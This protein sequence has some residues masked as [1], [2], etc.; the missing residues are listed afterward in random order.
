MQGSKPAQDKPALLAAIR[1]AF[2]IYEAEATLGALE[3]CIDAC[4]R[5][6]PALDETKVEHGNAVLQLAELLGDR[7]TK[8]RS[9]AHWAQANGLIDKFR[10]HIPDGDWR[11][12]LYA[13]A[14]G[15]LL[16]RRA[17]ATQAADDIANA[18]S[19]LQ[20]ARAMVRFGSFVNRISSL[21]QG[22]LRLRRFEAERDPGDLEAALADSGAVLAS[23]HTLPPHV[24]ATAK[25]FARAAYL[26]AD[27]V[28]ADGHLDLA[29]DA[30][31][32][33]LALTNDPIDISDLQGALGSLLRERFNR[34]GAAA[35]ID[36]A[37]EAYRTC[38]RLPGLSDAQ[39]AARIDNLGNGL[40]A[41]YAS[42]KD[43]VDLDAMV[44]CHKEA[45][46][47]SMTDSPDRARFHANLASS[48]LTRWRSCR[49]RAALNEAHATLMAGLRCEVVPISV[50]ALLNALMLEALLESDAGTGTDAHLNEAVAA[51]EA[52]LRAF[53]SSEGDNPVPYR[54]AARARSSPVTRRLLGALL[55]RAGRRSETK[56]ADLRRAVAIGEAA[57]V[58]LL[59]REL[60]RRSLAA[61]ADIREGDLFSEKQ[62]LAE[63]AAY[64]VHDMAPADNLSEARRLRRIA[65]RRSAWGA[66][67]QVWDEISA[68]CPAG[69]EYVRIRR[70]VSAALDTALQNRPPDWLLLSML[71]IEELSP[72]GRWQQGFCVIALPPAPAALQL[73]CSGPHDAVTD[74]Q[75]LFHE[76]VLGAP[77]AD[78]SNETWWR[79]PAALFRGKPADTQAQIMFSTNSRGLNLPWQLLFERTG[80]RDAEGTTPP[81]VV[82]PS[83]VLVAEADAGGNE[84]WQE[85]RNSAEYFGLQDDSGVADNVR[86]SLRMPA[87]PSKPALV[88]GDP[89]RDLES[90]SDEAV[91]VAKVLSVEPLLGPAANIE[92]VR[93]GFHIAR[94]V[95]IAA[96]ASFNDQDPLASVLRLADGN[97]SARDLIGSW[98]TSELVVLSA[99]ESGTGAPVRGGEESD[100]P[101]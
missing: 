27:L 31:R 41:R 58:P 9:A 97:L 69:A 30:V 34:D 54:L 43:V 48:L 70:D 42:R 55:R 81:V 83:L 59:T 73:L 29:V 47:L 101:S 95:H 68:T 87:A 26:H 66:L 62:L 80:W 93:E 19:R 39:R 16:Y 1:Q 23:E 45:L 74:A 46:R 60:L 57:K 99:C 79:C 71:D 17:D 12:P 92:A 77:D 44:D 82:V 22:N 100:W 7:W 32:R 14:Q 4:Q 94:I 65:Q 10:E 24:V 33:A 37:I 21:Y 20:E 2:S 61:P 64:D 91:N 90:A 98:S 76:Q 49:D 25:T 6:I 53:M 78:P 28:R 72:E 3:R 18:L 85:L 67:E 40:A 89:L 36:D 13:L 51:G 5:L 86:V 52:A 8:T 35:D 11:E 84:E 38:T 96:H 75:E 56:D 63:L 88:V 50:I 15:A